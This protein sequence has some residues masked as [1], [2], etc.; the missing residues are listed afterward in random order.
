MYAVVSVNDNPCTELTSDITHFKLCDLVKCTLPTQE[1]CFTGAPVTPAPIILSVGNAHCN[2]GIEWLD[3]NGN[4]IPGNTNQSSYQP[5]PILWT[6]PLT[7]CKQVFNY[8]AQVTGPCGPETC[9]TTITLFNENAPTGIIEVDPFEVIPICQG[10]DLTL[11]FQP[12]CPEEPQPITWKWLKGP[13]LAMLTHF[14]QLGDM[15]PIVNTNAV[16]QDVW[17]GIETQ[18]GICPAK[19]TK[20]FIDMIDA[21]KLLSF[22]ASHISPC[23]NN[24][25]QLNITYGSDVCPITVKWYKDG[26]LIHTMMNVTGG[27]ANYNYYDASLNGNYSGNYN[28]IIESTCCPDQIRK[29]IVQS[30]D[31]P[32]ILLVS[33]PCFRCNS[34]IV[35]LEAMVLNTNGLNCSFQWYELIGG[36]YVPLSGETTPSIVLDRAG[37]FK[38]IV[39]CGSCIL[40]QDFEFVQCGTSATDDFLKDQINVYPNP[41]TGHLTIQFKSSTEQD[42]TLILMD[43]LGKEVNRSTINIGS[44]NY[45]FNIDDLAGIYIIQLTDKSGNSS[46]RK[47]IKIE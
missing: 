29:S 26:L 40:E 47:V 3:E 34:E 13:T 27:V 31:E 22:N 5:P 11:T 23:R 45:S 4:P 41:T 9:S 32:L 42:L 18:N 17:Y 21:L 30:L 25:V 36:S 28:V 24:G 37:Q 35:L 15:N 1:Y 20:I 38:V 8:S 16:Y 39:Q 46:Q 2:F 19:I 6:A 43:V 33:G 10:E 44:T 14:P 12:V 7:D